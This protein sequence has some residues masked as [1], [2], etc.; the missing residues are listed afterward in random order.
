MVKSGKDG[1]YDRKNVAIYWKNGKAVPF[2]VYIKMEK[3]EM[4]T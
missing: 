2:K 3:P 1:K 4:P